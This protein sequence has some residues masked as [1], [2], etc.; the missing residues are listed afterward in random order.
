MET[1][2]RSIRKRYIT[3][4]GLQSYNVSTLQINN[5]KSYIQKTDESLLRH[6]RL[7]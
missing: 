6:M 2:K 7:Y 1:L 4:K 3:E 5:K